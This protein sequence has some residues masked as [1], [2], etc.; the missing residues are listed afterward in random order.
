MSGAREA[1]YIS[2]RPISANTACRVAREKKSPS[3]LRESIDDEDSTI[4]RP[5]ISRKSVAPNSRKNSGVSA[6]N[7]FLTATMA[8]GAGRS[9]S[10]SGGRR[11]VV[12]RCVVGR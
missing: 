1:R 4:T 5:K 7:S 11:C 6:A 9:A 3:L 8:V 2:G 10:G 12:G